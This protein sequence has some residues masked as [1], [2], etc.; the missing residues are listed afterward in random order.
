VLC[1]QCFSRF[2][3]PLSVFFTLTT[4]SLPLPLLRF[5]YRYRYTVSDTK[6]QLV[7]YCVFKMTQFVLLRQFYLAVFCPFNLLRCLVCSACFS[8][9]WAWP[10]Y[11]SD[12]LPIW[13]LQSNLDET[14]SNL[15]WKKM[16][17]HTF[18]IFYSSAYSTVLI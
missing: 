4:L 12:T 13:Q 9:R 14:H 10:L 11:L 18:Q 15:L 3:W 16:Y 6:I 5:R 2:V 1:S 8:D 7:E 17:W